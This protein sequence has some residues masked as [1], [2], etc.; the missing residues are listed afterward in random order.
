MPIFEKIQLVIHSDP[1]V[2]GMVFEHS[3]DLI[4]REDHSLLEWM[5]QFRS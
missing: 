1:N 3:G 4:A 2:A 5:R